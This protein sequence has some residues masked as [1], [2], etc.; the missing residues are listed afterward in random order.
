[1]VGTGPDEDPKLITPKT[2]RAPLKPGWQKTVTPV[3]C[4][5]TVIRVDVKVCHTQ[6]L[7]AIA[8]RIHAV[9]AW[10]L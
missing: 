3:M 9:C 6:I 7:A 8:N 5:Y 4:A 2:G 1:M 10:Q